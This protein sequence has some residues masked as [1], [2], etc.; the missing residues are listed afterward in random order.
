MQ[1]EPVDLSAMATTIFEELRAQEPHRE[2]RL[3]ITP[4]LATRGDAGLLRTVLDNLL[5][6]AWKYSGKRAVASIEFGSTRLKALRP[7]TDEAQDCT[8]YYVR[9]NGAGFDLRFAERLFKPFQRLHSAS[10]FAG[11]GVGLA[12]VRRIVQRHGG[13][14]WAQAAVDQ[15]ACFFFTLG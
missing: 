12:S 13:E 2:V 4:G 3:T 10:E 15:G 11:S 14:I 5:G 8:V 9:D 6:N 1:R 7:E